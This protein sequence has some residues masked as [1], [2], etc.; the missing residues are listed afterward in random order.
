MLDALEALCRTRFPLSRREAAAAA[1][2]VVVVVVVPLVVVAL[3]LLDQTVDDDDPLAGWRWWWSS[4]RMTRR[5]PSWE[6]TSFQDV[7]LA[8]TTGLSA[9]ATHTGVSLG[10]VWNQ[11]PRY[12][13]GVLSP[14]AEKLLWLPAWKKPS[15]NLPL[16]DRSVSPPVRPWLGKRVSAVAA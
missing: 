8:A 5:L 15:A 16:L 1:M 11:I 12:H 13:L 9:L 7:R 3:V 14:S 6:I 10:T 2:V 4:S